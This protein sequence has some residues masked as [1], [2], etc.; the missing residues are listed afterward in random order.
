MHAKTCFG[1]LVCLILF[2]F[3]CVCVLVCLCVCA[4]LCLCVLC[5]CFNLWDLRC[6]GLQS[7]TRIFRHCGH[8]SCIHLL[9]AADSTGHQQVPQCIDASL[10]TT[11]ACY[12]YVRIFDT[13]VGAFIADSYRNFQVSFVD[14]H[15]TMLTGASSGS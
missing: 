5:F 14:R 10:V 4:S 6:R 9:L 11:I 12:Q 13:W 15:S 8:E 1:P 2:H 7:T 3:M